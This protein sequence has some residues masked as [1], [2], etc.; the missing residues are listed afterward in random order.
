MNLL[1]FGGGL[2]CK[3]AHIL[4]LLNMNNCV[5]GVIIDPNSELKKTVDYAFN[6]ANEE[7]R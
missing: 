6:W 4:V 1:V 7:V 5:L 3:P 2:Y